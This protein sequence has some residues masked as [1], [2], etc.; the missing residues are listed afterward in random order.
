[1]ARLAAIISRNGWQTQGV[2]T[3]IPA[4]VSAVMAEESKK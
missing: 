1:M 3:P 2:R 4:A